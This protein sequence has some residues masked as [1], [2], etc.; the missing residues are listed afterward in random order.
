MTKLLSASDLT[1][2]IIIIRSERVARRIVSK[3]CGLDNCV[4]ADSLQC[5]IWGKWP[6]KL[7]YAFRNLDMTFNQFLEADELDR[8]RFEK[9]WTFPC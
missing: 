4:K 9:D 3:H 7:F 6:W 8:L 2:Q 5:S 1:G